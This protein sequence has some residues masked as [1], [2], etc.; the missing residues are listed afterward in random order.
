MGEV[1]TTLHVIVH[2]AEEG[3]YWAEVLELPGCMSQGETQ[4][5]V[6]ANIKAA[7][8]AI[9][10]SYVADGEPVPLQHSATVETV[11]VPVPA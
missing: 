3:G 10:D 8:R 1:E 4:P 6:L 2:E 11:Q 5:E 9:I 7:I